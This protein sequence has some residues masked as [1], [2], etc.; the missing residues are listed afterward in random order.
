MARTRD[1]A[2]S[3][4]EKF[5]SYAK[6]NVGGAKLLLSV[7]KRD[8]AQIESATSPRAIG[9]GSGNAL[10]PKRRGRKPGRKPMAIAAS[11]Q[12][13]K[14]E[15]LT[16][17]VPAKRRGRPAGSKNKAKDGA[18]SPQPASSVPTPASDHVE[19]DQE[20]EP[21]HYQQPTEADL[22]A[23]AGARGDR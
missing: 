3:L 7:F 1:E 8:V 21:I 16:G 22:Q 19:S 15:G 5:S 2:L 6:Y 10:A 20:P 18:A 12:P 17:A 13:A 23:M 4:M 9:T 11:S 14:P